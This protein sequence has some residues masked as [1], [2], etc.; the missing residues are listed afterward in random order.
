MIVKICGITN[1]E[2][3]LAAA[4]AGASALGF[5]F[6]SRSPRYVAPE[7]AQAI[8]DRL[9]S[10]IL[11]V[12]VF[13]NVPAVVAA[14]LAAT[15]PL[16]IAQLHG[17]AIEYP[18][19][20][21]LWRAWPAAEGLN[22]DEFDAG[23]VEAVLLDAPSDALHGGTGQTFDWRLAR[24][25]RLRIVL[26][27]GLDAANVRQAIAA[28]QPWGV[29]ACSKLESEPGRKDHVRVRQFIQAALA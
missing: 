25:G 15:L 23:P 3:A 20:V 12:G 22:L 16:D 5:N 18:E 11:K 14:A 1:L 9:P 7:R 13:V 10:N 6:Y 24:C 26:A 2:D 27:G 4:E 21:R 17:E 19:G 28:A 29:D 8:I